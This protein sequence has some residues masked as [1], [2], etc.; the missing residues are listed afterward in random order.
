MACAILA[1]PSA[2]SPSSSSVASCSAEGGKVPG[3][4]QQ[5]QR[6]GGNPFFEF[7]NHSRKIYKQTFSPNLPMSAEARQHVQEQARGA[8]GN[9]SSDEQGLWRCIH[10]GR[11]T[12]MRHQV[13]EGQVVASTNDDKARSSLWSWSQGRTG[14]NRF[15]LTRLL[16]LSPSFVGAVRSMRSSMTA[17]LPWWAQCPAALR[18]TLV[19]RATILCSAAAIFA[20]TCVAMGSATRPRAPWKVF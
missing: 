13:G 9:M 4:R 7:L 14:S 18:I 1:C 17:L 15:Q 2:L 3:A 10:V 19:K 16:R 11:S 6:H 20:N 8:W 5:R 12:N